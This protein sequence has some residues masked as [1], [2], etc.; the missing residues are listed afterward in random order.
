MVLSLLPDKGGPLRR[1]LNLR[2]ILYSSA[3]YDDRP[4]PGPLPIIDFRSPHDAADLVSS[5]TAKRRGVWAG[6]RVSDDSVIGG[7]STSVLSYVDG[8]QDGHN[9]PHLHW[10]GNISTKI[11][12][13]NPKSRHITR[14]GFAAIMTP[15]FPLGIPLGNKYG[16]LEIC[17]RTDGRMYAVNLKVETYF[18]EDLYQGFI[19]GE[20]LVTEGVDVDDHDLDENHDDDATMSSSSFEKESTIQKDERKNDDRQP[21]QLSSTIQSSTTTESTEASLTSTA[22][23]ATEPNQSHDNK[24]HQLSSTIQS[25]KTTEST[26]TTSTEPNQSL[27]VREYIQHRYNRIYQ[28]DPSTHPITG[29]PPQSFTRLILPFTSFTLT[30]QGRARMEQRVLDGAVTIESIGFTLMDGRDGEFA[31]DLVSVRAVNVLERE[32]VGTME[33]EEREE[34]MRRRFREEAGRGG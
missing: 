19:G 31:F 33:D 17:C 16:G 30:S 28:S 22:S 34:E 11:N 21:H 20:G 7:S 4:L 14:S 29:F 1:F 24:P 5:L 8:S 13:S 9:V 15:E 26:T 32:V 18:P 10:T 27:D 2:R 12:H 6:W 23:T 25:S 3:Y